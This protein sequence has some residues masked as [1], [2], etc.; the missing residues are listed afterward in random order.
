MIRVF[1]NA[2]L[3]ELNTFGIEAVADRLVE[4]ASGDDIAPYCVDEWRVIGGGSNVLLTGD[5]HGTLLRPVGNEIHKEGELVRVEAGMKWDDFVRW[6]VAEGLWGAENLSHIPGTV[7]AAPV[8]NIGAY[9]VEAKDIIY[10]VEFYDPAV[11]EVR[12]LRGEDC[13]FGYRD[14]IFKRGRRVVIL[15]VT[16]KLSQTPRPRLEYGDLKS[17]KNPA[18]QE[19]RD[20]IIEIRRGKLP[21]RGSAGS[22]FKNPVVSPETVA[23][24]KEQ[25][26][27]MPIY[28]GNKLAAGW[29]I[30]RAGWRGRTM[31]RAGVHPDQALVLVNLGG[32]TGQEILDLARAVQ[33]SVKEKFG[34][35]IEMEVNVW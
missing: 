34:V 33:S 5:L 35:E 15:A 24:L 32:A 30:D 9:G 29:L 25:Y 19:I 22:F 18:L 10:S 27:D 4:F 13:E 21:E 14:S 7:G 31:G 17:L 6:T 20:K 3:G 23:R 8:Q 16:F 11:D 2:E 26:P 1:E 28:N 12:E